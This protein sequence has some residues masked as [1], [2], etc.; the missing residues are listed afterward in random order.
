MEISRVRRAGEREHEDHDRNHLH[1][2]ED[3]VNGGGLLDADRDQRRDRKDHARGDQV[4][5]RVREIDAA[6]DDREMCDLCPFRQHDLVVREERL[7]VARP[8][9]SDR[10]HAD[11]V[12]EDQVPTDDPRHGLTERRVRIRVGAT[13]DRHHRR[14]LRVAERH[15]DARETRQQERHDHA[16]A[17]RDGPRADRREDAAQHRAEPHADEA[18]PPEDASERRSPGGPRAVVGLSREQSRGERRQLAGSAAKS[19]TRGRKASRRRRCA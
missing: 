12:L 1:V 9:R 8:R 6:V 2:H 4:D 18:R 13:R 5:L 14:E 3:R 7:R 19:R 15:E 10:R 11:A 17:R 16:R